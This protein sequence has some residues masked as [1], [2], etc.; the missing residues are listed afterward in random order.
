MIAPESFNRDGIIGK[1]IIALGGS[2]VSFI[3]IFGLDK[4]E[5]AEWTKEV[6]DK[7]IVT[8]IVG[9]GLMIGFA[10]EQAFDKGVEALSDFAP[11]ALG[12]PHPDIFRFG[13]A[14]FVCIL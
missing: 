4:L 10:W 8:I 5:D 3:I 14:M 7:I 2:I 6:A 12:F 1:T 11:S 13:L 9:Q